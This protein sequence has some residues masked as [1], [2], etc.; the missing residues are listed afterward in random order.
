[1]GGI[2][3][4]VS[5]RA[6]FWAAGAV[7]FLGA[8]YGW[9]VLP[10]SLPRERRSP[11][12]WRRANPVGALSMLKARDALLGLA[13]VAFLHRLAHDALPSLFVLYGDYRYGWSARTVGFALMGVG[14][15]SMI[16]QGGLVRPAVR[17]LGE[18][19]ALLAGLGFGAA[20]FVIYALA[21][22]GLVFM[23]GIV[24][25]G[26]FGLAYPSLQGMMTRRVGPEEQGRL[27]GALGSL[28]GIAAIIAPG[29][30]TQVFATAIRPTG[31]GGGALPGAPFLLAG[32]L[33][34]VGMVVAQR[35]R[36]RQVGAVPVATP[37]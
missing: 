32:L 14:I 37:E 34:V 6:P 30:F 35:E 8:A 33:L 36:G 1:V 16:V 22:T 21:P 17:R 27:Q 3:G 25:G 9:F 13:V 31:F 19:V 12:Q 5:L 24:V 15:V 28:A 2:L 10:E 11:F 18:P 26:L 20:A 29:M 4:G 7:S 23:G